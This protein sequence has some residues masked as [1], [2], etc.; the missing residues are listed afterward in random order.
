MNPV[1]AVRRVAKRLVAV[2]LSVKEEVALSWA[3]LAVLTFNVP[4]VLDPAV[5][6]VME[7][8]ARVEVPTTVRVPWEVID[9]VATKVEPVAL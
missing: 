1:T 3:T 2:A 6:E 5:S 7:V 4:M 9:E 8:V